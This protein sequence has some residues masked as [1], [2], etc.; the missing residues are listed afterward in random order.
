[1][2]GIPKSRVRYPPEFR[3]RGLELVRWGE[4]RRVLR[5]GSSQARSRLRIGFRRPITPAIGTR[6]GRQQRL[7]AAV[8]FDLP[9]THSRLR[10][11][12]NEFATDTISKAFRRGLPEGR[13]PAAR[14]VASH[15]RPFAPSRVRAVRNAPDRPALRAAGARRGPPQ[16]GVAIRSRSSPLVDSVRSP[17]WP[18]K[19]P[20]Y[21]I[22]GAKTPSI[23]PE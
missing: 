23:L 9:P 21:G 10:S 12:A 18:V 8:P 16:P 6:T 22:L 14:S 1:M 17:S 15:S 19:K 20:G 11:R 3:L 5:G 2:S 7:R 13:P 4:P